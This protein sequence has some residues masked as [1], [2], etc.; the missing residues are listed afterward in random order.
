MQLSA[1]LVVWETI[2]VVEMVPAW[3]MRETHIS[4]RSPQRL[5]ER[6]MILALPP[7]IADTFELLPECR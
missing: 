1:A 7:A 4:R 3:L 2:S 5:R 6:I